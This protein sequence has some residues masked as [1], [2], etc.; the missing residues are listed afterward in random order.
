VNQDMSLET[1]QDGNH[2]IIAQVII[3]IKTSRELTVQMA[4]RNFSLRKNVGI[5]TGRKKI[6]LSEAD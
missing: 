5:I 2:G 4:K 1:N 3:Q 6:I